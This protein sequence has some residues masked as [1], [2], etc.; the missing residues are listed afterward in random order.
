MTLNQYGL[1]TTLMG[2]MSAVFT[3]YPEIQKVTLFG[4]RVTGK[5]RTGSDIDLAITTSQADTLS[6]L[7]HELDELNSPYLID[8]VDESSITNPALIKH[9]QDVG[10]VIYQAS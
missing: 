7:H 4:S 3:R 8:L 9:I 2:K 1:P 10:V 5:F 6:H